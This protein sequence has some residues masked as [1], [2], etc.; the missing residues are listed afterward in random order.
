LGYF[1]TFDPTAKILYQRARALPLPFGAWNIKH[2]RLDDDS[3]MK[4][5]KFFAVL[6][7]FHMKD[8]FLVHRFIA[9]KYEFVML[10]V[11]ALH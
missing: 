3:G 5:S 2:C 11:I 4:V 1:Y 7:I 10:F 6:F 8:T 9:A